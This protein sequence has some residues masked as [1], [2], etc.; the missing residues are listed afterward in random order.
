[1]LDQP[2]RSLLWRGLPTGSI[3]IGAA[4]CNST[5]VAP[6]HVAVI[7]RNQ[8]TPPRFWQRGGVNKG[9]GVSAEG[10]RSASELK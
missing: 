6:R 9:Q 5:C 7:G 2:A 3:N 10:T 4:G 8:N 1:M